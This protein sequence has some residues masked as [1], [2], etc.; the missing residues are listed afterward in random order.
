ML[1]HPTLGRL[2]AHP[3]V[4]AGSSPLYMRGAF[5]EETRPNLARRIVDLLGPG[6]GTDRAALLTVN[7]RK[8]HAPLRVRLRL[9]DGD[10]G[11]SAAAAAAAAAAATQ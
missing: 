6:E 7:D 9:V 3:S 10:G 1:Q 11:D 2:L 8:L 5:E 4:S